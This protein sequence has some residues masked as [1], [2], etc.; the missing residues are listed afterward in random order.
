MCTHSLTHG[1]NEVLLEKG[2]WQESTP[3]HSLLPLVAPYPIVSL[4]CPLSRDTFSAIAAIPQEGAIP[5]A[6]VPSFTQT[7]QFDTPFCNISRDTC[8]I[9]QE[10]MHENI[11][12]ILSLKV[13][14]DMKSIAN[15]HLS[16]CRV[17]SSSLEGRPQKVIKLS[18]EQ[19]YLEPI[20]HLQH[21]ARKL[22]STSRMVSERARG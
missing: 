16:S 21:C 6:L 19:D 1:T 9:P 8:A 10:N 2:R 20:G 5:P 15:G 13:S 3:N 7:Y 11:Y 18:F 17:E 14:R 12:A 4:R 22:L